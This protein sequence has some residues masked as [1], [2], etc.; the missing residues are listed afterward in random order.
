MT[1]QNSRSRAEWIEG[2]AAARAGI[3]DVFDKL[4]PGDHL[5]IGDPNGGLLVRGLPSLFAELLARD[6]HPDFAARAI[7]DAIL[8]GVLD[9]GSIGGSGPA[10]Q[11]RFP[12]VLLATTETEPAAVSDTPA[13]EADAVESKEKQSELKA[14]SKRTFPDPQRQAIADL[15]ESATDTP[16]GYKMAIARGVIGEEDDKIGEAKRHL[17]GIRAADKRAAKRTQSELKANK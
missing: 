3:L 13:V 16:H 17:A 7:R 11:F 9:N 8:N 1:D 14:N 2:I 10:G 4:P 12:V 15:I 6:H 5:L